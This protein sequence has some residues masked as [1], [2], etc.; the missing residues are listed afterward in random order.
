MSCQTAMNVNG[1]LCQTAR[2]SRDHASCSKMIDPQPMVED[3]VQTLEQVTN[4][5]YQ[6]ESKY[7]W[8]QTLSRLSHHPHMQ[9]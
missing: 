5:T 4:H 7:L 9:V 1:M 8:V 6:F 3:I 2:C